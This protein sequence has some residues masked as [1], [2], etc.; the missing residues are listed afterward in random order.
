MRKLWDNTG[1]AIWR[2]LNRLVRLD[3]FPEPMFV[4][5]RNLE[6]DDVRVKCAY[7]LV[8]TGST[9]DWI[10]AELQNLADQ[11]RTPLGKSTCLSFLKYHVAWKQ[12]VDTFVEQRRQA[13]AKRVVLI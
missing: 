9:C 5:I 13:R 10:E 2:C 4:R 1:G 3:W 12:T 11:C 7:K 8:T 6:H